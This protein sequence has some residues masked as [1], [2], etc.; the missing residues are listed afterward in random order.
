[1]KQFFT[2]I[3]LAAGIL[4]AAESAAQKPVTQDMMREALKETLKEKMRSWKPGAAASQMKTTAGDQRMTSNPVSVEEAE[5]SL[6][7]HP[8]DS[9]KVVISFMEQTSTGLKFPVYYSSNGGLS[10][11]KSTFNTQNVLAQDFPGHMAAGGGDPV[12]AWDKNGRLYFSWIYLS[13]N[14]NTA[15]TG[16]FTLNYAYSDNNGQTWTVPAGV[17]HFIGRGALDLA[18]FDLIDYFDGVCDRQWM[19]VDNSNGPRQGTLYCSFMQMPG[20]VTQ[21]SLFGTAVKTKLPNATAFGPATVAFNSETQFANVE[22][23]NNGTVHVSFADLTTDQIMHVSSND[24]AATFSSAHTAGTGFNLFGG[25]NTIHD[26]ENAATNMAVD[27]AGNL[28]VVYS[29]FPGNS[30][31]SFYARSVNGGVTW[32]TPVDLNAM[33]SGNKT[34][35]P[36]VAASGNG[37]T[38]SL[39]VVDNADS[40]RYIQINSA[41]NGATFGAPVQIGTSATYFPGYNNFEFFGDYN[42]SVRSGCTVYTGW[43]DGRDGTGPKVYFSRNSYCTPTTGIRDITG[44]NGN[45]QLQEMFPNPAATELTLRLTANASD[46]AS[47]AI[48]D[49]TGKQVNTVSTDLVKGSR[50]IKLS[51][52]GL[53]AGLYRLTISSDKGSFISRSLIKQ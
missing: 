44:I 36:V 45:V 6:A 22:V 21:T 10:W 48:F 49:L 8:M 19:A 18:T 41:D 33:F 30:V 11:T 7:V 42:R 24:G 28:H 12:F 15:D 35:M 3:S 50:D 13:L 52:Q 1:M 5:V 2:M 16:F 23:D 20:D 37:V 26:R 51:L 38:I 25:N 31:S 32:S 46:K 17:D 40:A 29:S 9:N 47:I 27:G 39:H 4:Y 14:P 43:S 34:L 53:A